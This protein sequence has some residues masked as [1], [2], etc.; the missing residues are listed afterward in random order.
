MSD[1][2]IIVLDY[3][4]RGWSVKKIAAALNVSHQAISKTLAIARSRAAKVLSTC[5]NDEA[6]ELLEG[7][8]RDYRNI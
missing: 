7:A 4:L 1:R 6:R 5:P 3:N 2:Q 8:L